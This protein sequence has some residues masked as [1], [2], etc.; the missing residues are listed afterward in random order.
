MKFTFLTYGTEGDTRPLLALARALVIQGHEARLLADA[1]IA[2]RAREHGIA[3]TALAGSMR[4]AL[5]PGAA[6]ADVVAG[7]GGAGRLARAFAEAA[8]D[9]T[10]A[11]MR[12]TREAAEGSDVLVFS[13]LA[14]YAGLAVAE[15]LGLPCVGAGLWPMTPTGDFASLFLR[16]PMLP[17]WAN[18][19]SHRLVNGM[20]WKMFQ[21]A[22][23]AGRKAVFGQAPR[24]RMWQGYPILYGCSPTLLPRP[25]EWAPEVE[26]CGAWHL[27]QPAYAPPPALR[28]FLDE[29]EAPVYVGFGSMAGFDRAA[30][31][32]ALREA[33]GSRR[34]LFYPGWSGI[35]ASGLPS[36]FYVLGDTPHDWLFPRCSL[37]VH[38][39]GAG[40][41][42]AAA[43][44]G[45]ASVVIPFAGDQF[46]WA[47]R[48]EA[49]GIAAACPDARRLDGA[50]LGALFERA[51]APAARASA[52]AVA[53]RMRSEDGVAAACARLVSGVAARPGS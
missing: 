21:P 35:D 16:A 5:A 43:R 46:F 48:M 11:W 52:L 10:E 12:T 17:R 23:N 37:I 27:P 50:R 49:L 18:R 38:H 25:A 53:G 44:S 6:L 19:F 15:G 42:H 36:N 1:A 7:K 51:S 31:L 40:T 39:G 45:V 24:R 41:A 13:G 30:L 3:F 34:A 47:R 14:S 8:R 28:R 32:R 4:D 22:V 33:V 9:Q 2:D 29:G 26:L 20:T